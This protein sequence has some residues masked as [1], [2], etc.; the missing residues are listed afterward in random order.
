LSDIGQGEMTMEEVF[1]ERVA[2]HTWT[3]THRRPGD[4][5]MQLLREELDAK[6]QHLHSPG[7]G[8]HYIPGPREYWFDGRAWCAEVPS[9]MGAILAHVED[10]CHAYNLNFADLYRSAYPDDE[11]YVVERED[12]DACAQPAE[13]NDLVHVLN[14]LEDVNYSQLATAL[15]DAL[16]L[17]GDR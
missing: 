17:E 8:Y 1:Y 5:T 13:H 7:D 15:S 4:G 14:D 11:V 9:S 16:E 6:K 2:S 10:I 3:S 12:H